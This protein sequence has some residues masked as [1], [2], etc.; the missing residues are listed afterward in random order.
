[1]P[2]GIPRTSPVSAAESPPWKCR[3]EDRALLDGQPSEAAL[4][5]VAVG[6]VC[7]RIADARRGR[8]ERVDDESPATVSIGL[9]ITRS[10]DESMDPRVPRIGI[11][12]GPHISPGG[13]ERLLDR[14]LG[15]VRI[16]KDERCDA[17]QPIGRRLRQDGEGG[18]I[19][20]TC[21]FDECSI[22]PRHPCGA[23]VVAALT[24]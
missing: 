23:T 24:D 9:S 21:P 18:V 7:R 3:Y 20:L 8:I 5:L 2:S 4:D 15:A 22:H 10:D 14:V 16:P 6:K 12:Q 1:M 13:D 19:A 17:V 11:P